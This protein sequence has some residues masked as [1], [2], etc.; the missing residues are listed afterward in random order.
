VHIW[1]V[2]DAALVA[3]LPADHDTPDV[4]FSP[5]GR[6]LVTSG[7]DNRVRVWRVQP[8]AG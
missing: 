1:R 6:W 2:S 4:A 3:S 8:V 7:E 5:D